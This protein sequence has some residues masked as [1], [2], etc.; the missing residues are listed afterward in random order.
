MAHTN[1]IIR[2]IRERSS[3]V[4]PDI[5]S[6]IKHLQRVLVSYSFTSETTSVQYFKTLWQIKNLREQIFNG[7]QK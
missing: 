3:A 6:Q 4:D 2:R 7:E 1:S 5:N